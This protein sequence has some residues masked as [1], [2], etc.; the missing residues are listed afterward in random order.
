MLVLAFALLPGISAQPL[1][2]VADSL[3]RVLPTVAADTTRINMLN[4]IAYEYA[5][6]LQVTGKS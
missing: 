3:K 5:F 2:K 4:E 6:A 1:S